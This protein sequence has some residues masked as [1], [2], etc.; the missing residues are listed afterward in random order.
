MRTLVKDAWHSDIHFLTRM[1]LPTPTLRCETTNFQHRGDIVNDKEVEA[2][3]EELEALKEKLEALRHAYPDLPKRVQ[4][5]DSEAFSA[6]QLALDADP[7]TFISDQ[8]TLIAASETFVA[9]RM[10]LIV[11]N[12]TSIENDK[13]L[14]G[15]R[16]AHIAERVALFETGKALLAE[17]VALFETG[18]ALLKDRVY[19]ANRAAFRGVA[20]DDDGGFNEIGFNEKEKQLR[21]EYEASL[22]TEVALF[23]TGKALLRNHE[24]FLAKYQSLLA[25]YQMFLAKYQSL[26]AEY[27]S[28]L[29]QKESLWALLKP[30]LKDLNPIF[31]ERVVLGEVGHRVFDANWEAWAED[32]KAM[33]ADLEPD[34]LAHIFDVRRAI[35]DLEEY[36]SFLGALKWSA[37]SEAKTLGEFIGT[38]AAF[39]TAYLAEYTAFL[40]GQEALFTKEAAFREALD[41]KESE[42]L[43]AILGNAISAKDSTIQEAITVM[44]SHKLKRKLYARRLGLVLILFVAVFLGV[45]KFNTWRADNSARATCNDVERVQANLPTP[46]IFGTDYTQAQDYP[47]LSVAALNALSDALDA[48]RSDKRHYTYLLYEVDL[49]YKNLDGTAN[50]SEI[51]A[52][53]NIL[54]LNLLPFCIARTH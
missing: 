42:Q 2:L 14:I 5:V 22:S 27:A 48:R 24:M 49:L 12:E 34:K 31:A 26:L 23:E 6:A 30:Q 17:R 39:H 46:F 33:T 40:A 45:P 21:A 37:A 1:K 15:E 53:Q 16:V 8:L 4:G 47:K 36:P 25:E 3:K 51:H 18:K 7:Q 28:L 43:R 29:A 35:A 9:D 38:E 11:V 10:T 13:G 50:P 41:A 20:Y 54:E 32:L 44:H 52:P 19:L